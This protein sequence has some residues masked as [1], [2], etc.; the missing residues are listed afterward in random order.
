MDVF[1]K[2]VKF[3]RFPYTP[4]DAPSRDYHV[5]NKKYVDDNAREK[6]TRTVT[7]DTTMTAADMLIIANDTLGNMSVALGTL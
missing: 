6:T 5:A 1:S 4:D 3:L 2:I 7:T